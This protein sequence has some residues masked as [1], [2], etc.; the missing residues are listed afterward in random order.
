MNRHLALSIAGATAIF[1]T[2]ASGAVAA[3][4]GILSVGASKPVGQLSA[5]NVSKLTVAASTNATAAGSTS[6]ASP[7][8]IVPDPIAGGSTD[9]VGT[10]RP[11]PSSS[12]SVGSSSGSSSSGSVGVSGETA[13]AGS[14]AAQGP[15]AATPPTSIV[16]SQGP[17]TPGVVVTTPPTVVKTPTPPTTS[18]S[19][20]R[21]REEHEEE[22]DD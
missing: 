8:Q 22:D 2:A 18:R 4:V 19:R 16:R 14:G 11:L 1:V 17:S 10:Q 13:N 15:S 6:E 21:E 3:N 7:P 9:V 12:G 5:A 20:Q